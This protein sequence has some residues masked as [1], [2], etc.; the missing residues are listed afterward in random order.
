MRFSASALAALALVAGQAAA[1]STL[2]DP[3]GGGGVVGP[4]FESSIIGDFSSL[5]SSNGFDLGDI[6]SALASGTDA[7]PTALPTDGSFPSSIAGVGNVNDILSSLQANPAAAPSFLSSYLANP[8][9]SSAVYANPTLSSLVAQAT[10]LL[11]VVGGGS[12]GASA[13]GGAVETNPVNS[14][15][16]GSTGGTSGGGNGAAGLK[17]AAVA[18]TGVLGAAVAGAAMVL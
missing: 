18:F 2:N 14:A 5:A 9:I 12:N 6:T 17:A 8:T 7:I 1:Q 16:G 4:G 15:G 3:T 11:G 10:S 13:D